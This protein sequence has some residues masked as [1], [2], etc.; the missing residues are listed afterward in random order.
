MPHLGRFA[1]AIV[2]S[3]L[4]ASS[5]FSVASSLAFQR[6]SC[7]RRLPSAHGFQCRPQLALF[8]DERS[9]SE[10]SVEEDDDFPDV[11]EADFAIAAE[12]DDADDDEQEENGDDDEQLLQMEEVQAPVDPD[13]FVFIPKA[14]VSPQPSSQSTRPK[15]QY[16]A[17]APGTVVHIK[18]GDISLAR[19]AWKK[20]RR[21]GS[22]LLVPCSVLNVDRQST[23]RWNLIYLLEKFGTSTSGQGIRISLGELGRRSRTHLKTSLKEQAAAMGYASPR[24][25]VENLLNKKAQETYGVKLVYI[26]D[27]GI[28]TSDAG[29]DDTESN[30]LALEAP[31][32][33]FRAQKRANEAA[34]L[35]FAD[36][37]QHEDTLQ[38]TGI[39]RNRRQVTEEDGNMYQL[40]PL[41]A[42]LRV[43]QEDVDTG[44][45]QDGSMHAAVVFTYDSQGDGGAPMLTLSLNPGRNQVRDRLKI[46]PSDH[47]YKPILNPKYMLKELKVGDGPIEGKV[48]RFVKGGALLDCGVGRKVNNRDV[49][50]PVKVFGLLRFKD[51]VAAASGDDKRLDFS[52]FVDIDVDD[53]D[54]EE[55]DWDEILSIDDLDLDRDLDD[56]DKDDDDEAE[57]TQD[58]EDDGNAELSSE[59]DE[60]FIDSEDI[61]HF[62]TTDDNGS[63]IYTDPET[64]ETKMVNN[65]GE[66]DE[67]FEVGDDNGREDYR[68]YRDSE[69]AEEDSR[70]KRPAFK[71]STGLKSKRLNV[72]DRVEVFVKLVSKQSNQLMVTMNPSVQGMTAKDLKRETGLSKKLSRLAKQLGGM[73]RIR[74]LQGQECDGVVKATSNAGDWLYVQPN[75]D[76]LPVG[77]ATVPADL[78]ASLA[79]GDAVRIQLQGVDED[80]G[81]LAMRILKKLAQ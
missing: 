63:L 19:K 15:S 2:G 54:A 44:H 77:V 61:T 16:A 37:N 8:G 76:N 45:I 52:A 24:E 57:S 20:R 55:E 42:A 74:E 60:A 48:I 66:A 50:D 1:V 22:P 59:D 75:M 70:P 12:N 28:V 73:H 35:Q 9:V 41:S 69:T 81:Q 10:Y 13:S 49:P 38:H 23:V 39:V 32:S 11:D 71:P 14:K 56:D 17:L 3:L 4:L 25:L 68:I 64:G 18:V 80:R 46:A 34:I 5:L 36:K 6:S 67:E 47:K 29:N 79:K 40:Q 62:F 26:N 53:D 78:D 58:V 43:N 30:N 31:L 72:G 21:S 27:D 51:A 7:S 33:R 65:A